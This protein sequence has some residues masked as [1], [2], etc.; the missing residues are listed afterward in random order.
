MAGVATADQYRW[1]L[2]VLPSAACVTVVQGL[3]VAGV[4]EALGGDPAS[5]LEPREPFAAVGTVGDVVVAIEPGGFQGSR[6]EVVR[7]ASRN[8]LAVSV[9][10]NDAH[11]LSRYAFAQDGELVGT[12]EPG[13]DR[14]PDAFVRMER[15][16]GLSLQP[17]HLTG[18]TDVW[19]LVPVLEDL[20][21]APR[22]RYHPLWRAD[23]ELAEAVAAADPDRQR[24][25]ARRAAARA[26]E[27]TGLE[28][29]ADTRTVL[30]RHPASPLAWAA[31]AAYRGTNPDPLA[32][33]LDALHALGMVAGG[34]L[35]RELCRGD[36][37]H[38]TEGRT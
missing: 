37:P 34:E 2:E 15:A 14:I 6:P 20:R 25:L 23:R 30:H 7:P 12:L 36:T 11:A 33:A 5:D 31:L 21:P 29:G 26:A 10:W 4:V 27:V 22:L 1:V 24:D 32:A 19:P 8:G 35:V 17:S 18:I 9:S 13:Y 16:T 3:D 28:M 38:D